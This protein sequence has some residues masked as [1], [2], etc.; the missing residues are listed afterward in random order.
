M[1]HYLPWDSIYE[2]VNSFEA[3]SVY[4]PIQ[5]VV[6][7]WVIGNRLPANVCVC[8]GCMLKKIRPTNMHYRQQQLMQVWQF[9][10]SDFT[11]ASGGMA[12]K[13]AVLNFTLWLSY[14]N[15]TF[16][17]TKCYADMNPN[18]K[19]NQT[20]IINRVQSARKELAS[21]PGLLPSD[22]KA[23]HE[24]TVYCI[25]SKISLHKPESEFEYLKS[26]SAQTG[27]SATTGAV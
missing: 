27:M 23:L 12:L 16:T 14:K 6:L 8:G 15:F 19:S 17:S 21:S 1:K 5:L 3:F 18:G 13:S 2:P 9:H 7:G 4:V 11:C 20:T 10:V 22:R 24:E 25:V 26:G